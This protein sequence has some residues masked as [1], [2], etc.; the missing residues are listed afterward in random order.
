[1]GTGE[2]IPEPLARL[3][4]EFS[5]GFQVLPQG[6]DT[7]PD[8]LPPEHGSLG[9]VPL[10]LTTAPCLAPQPSPLLGWLLGGGLGFQTLAL[11]DL[12]SDPAIWLCASFY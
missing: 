6:R 7:N 5:P 4:Q 9:K 10:L 3:F 2:F 12:G 1:M 11:M 8:L